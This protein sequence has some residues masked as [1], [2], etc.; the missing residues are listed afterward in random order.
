MLI[1]GL[2]T[3]QPTV[4]I[5]LLEENQK[6]FVGEHFTSRMESLPGLLKRLFDNFD[7]QPQN[8][9]A[10]GIITGPGNYTGIRAGMMVVKTLTYRYQIP[11]Y[12][13]SKLEA[14]LYGLRSLNMPLSPIFNVRQGQIYT[15]LGKWEE[16]AVYKV[17]P[18]SSDL[19]TWLKR[20]EEEAPSGLLCS[21]DPLPDQ[22]TWLPLGNLANAVAEWTREQLKCADPPQTEVQP[23][24]IRPA[25]QT[26]P[27]QARSDRQ[28]QN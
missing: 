16:R 10:I 22:K 23:F 21:P 20:L 27:A 17:E 19:E 4:Q 9:S 2:D 13:L 15:G 28:N 5:S 14:S 18:H 7:F 3:T 1:L 12:G 25:V 6:L 24:Y 11:L 26:G 8:L